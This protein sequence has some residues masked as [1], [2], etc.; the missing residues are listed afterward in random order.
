MKKNFSEPLYVFSSFAALLI[1][2]AMFINYMI[3]KQIRIYLLAAG[4][5][6]LLLGFVAKK[7][8][9]NLTEN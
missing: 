2:T 1:F 8:I 7:V 4:I 6:A 5:V 9:D 3:N